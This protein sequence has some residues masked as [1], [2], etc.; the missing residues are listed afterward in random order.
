MSISLKVA[1]ITAVFALTVPAAVA[2]ATNLSDA[3]LEMASSAEGAGPAVPAEL[4]PGA[5]NLD[6]WLPGIQQA[7]VI[8]VGVGLMYL[9]WQ[10][11]QDGL[12]GDERLEGRIRAARQLRWAAHRLSQE[13]LETEETS[14]PSN[15]LLGETEGYL[16]AERGAQVGQRLESRVRLKL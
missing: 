10:L 3:P 4:A 15:A 2:V 11:G 7:G 13:V 1:L 6:F 8:G 12:A 14:R 9:L 16:P 5:L